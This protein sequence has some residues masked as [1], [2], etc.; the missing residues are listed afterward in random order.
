VIEELHI[1][2]LGVIEDVSLRLAPGLTVVTGETGAGKTMIVTALELLLGSR[3]SSDLVRQGATA[4][5]VEA[6]VSVP[7]RPVRDGGGSVDARVDEATDGPTGVLPERS[8]DLWELAEDG[9]L[10]VSREIPAD[11][12][13]RARVGGRMVPVSQLTDLLGGHVEIHGQHEHVRLARADVQRR[14]L[15]RSAGEEHALRL[16]RYAAAYAAW[17]DAERRRA[18]LAQDAQARADRMD[19]LAR[20]VAE[21]DQL[22]LDAERDGRIETDLERLEHAEALREVLDAA[23]TALGGDGAGERI[24]IALHA[25]RRAPTSDPELSGLVERIGALSRDL[26]EVTADLATYALDVEADDARLEALQLRKRDLTVLMRRYGASVDDVLAHRAAAARQLAELEALVEGAA[27]IDDEVHRC[28]E[29]VRRLG[30]EVSDGRRAAATALEHVVATHLAGLALA[31]AR[32]EVR[33]T[34]P[35]DRTPTAD[36]LDDVD[37]L[38]TANP[39]ERATR[40]SEGASG[41]ERSRVALAIEVALADGD[42]TGVLVFDEVDAGVGGST[43]LAVGEQLARLAHAG[44]RRRQVLCVTHLAQVAAFADVHHVVEKRVIGGRTITGVRQV[45]EEERVAELSRMLGGEA[46]AEAGL[47]HA[48]SLLEAA[49]ARRSTAAGVA[50]G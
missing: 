38:L 30:T 47:D 7:D 31:H 33:V 28:L 12:R 8:D 37:V 41:G 4:A 18:L 26:S 1:R 49:R 25:L 40:L 19:R 9:A 10:I 20:E 35:S 48:R 27:T 32:V 34:S 14:L 43:A 23:V 45:A 15:D 11:G 16:E 29:V 24:A 50:A 13:S 5:V 44:S 36:G 3:A 46:T 17:R 39:G 2:G 42:D 22:A 21:I 6:L